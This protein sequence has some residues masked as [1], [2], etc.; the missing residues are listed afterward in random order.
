MDF[1]LTREQLMLRKLAV[2]FAKEVCEPEAA[3]LD[4]NHEF[5]AETWKKMAEIGLLRVNHDKKNGGVGH[6]SISEMIVIEELSKASLTHGATYALLGHGFPTF[7]EM[8]GTEEQ[9]EFFIPQVLDDGVI[10]SFCL[11]EP[12]AGSDAT[13]I[14]TSSTKDGD[15]YIINGSKC[16]VTAGDIAKYHIVV[17]IAD[18]Q[19]GEKGFNGFIVDADA[20]GISIGKIENKM[21]IRG[22]STAEV[23]FEDVRVPAG[24]M[25]GGAAGC[26][27]M[28]KFALG[29][30]DAARIGTG[31]QA[32]G[33]ATAAFEHAL[34]YSGERKQFGKPINANQGIAWYLADMACKLDMSRLL[35]YRAAALESEG[36][37]YSKEASM[38][39]L[40]AT[41]FG[42]EVV[43]TAL[44][45]HGGYGYM[46]DYP[47]ER[48]YRDIKITE[49]YEGS[50][51]I[52]KVVIA[53]HLIP[54]KPRNKDKKS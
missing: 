46:H 18:T 37:P 48:M 12:D 24:R 7:I 21:G 31:A 27:R 3:V 40:Y 32:L 17:C 4:E 44:Q 45:I 33:V 43:D 42:R 13:G 25:L 1:N 15:D 22:L 35:I 9:K 29:T 47:L 50:S 23:I 34:A 16:F 49:I 6:D 20:P 53:N 28:M 10:G 38:A 52:Q 54:R 19:A 30:L 36:K 51:E 2:Q 11:T 5:L 41:K 8:F 39:K 14:H 26:G